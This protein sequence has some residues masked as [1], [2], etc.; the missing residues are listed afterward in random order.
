[1][2]ELFRDTAFGHL[3]RL[4][5]RGKLLQ[6]P[7]ERDPSIWQQYVDEKKSANLAKYG[8]AEPPKDDDEDGNGS[9]EKLEKEQQADDASPTRQRNTTRMPS[10]GSERTRVDEDANATVNR[11]SGVKVDSEKGRD[12]NLVTWYGADDPENPQNWSLGKKCF[13]TAQICLLTT[14]VYIG[15]SIYTAGEESI[16]ETFGVSQVAA[17]LG[18]TLFVAGYGLGP[19]IW[20]PLSEIPQIGRNP[21][22][23]AT[24]VVFVAFQA[25]TALSVNFG[26]LLAFRFL[27]GFF[28][29][30]V[31]ATGGASIGDI[32]SPK[33]RAYAMSIWGIAAVCGPTLGPLV[34][35]FAVEFAPLGGGFTAPWTWPIWELMWLSA[36]CLVFLFFFFPETSANNILVRRARRLRK[37][38]GDDKLISESELMSQE[39]SGKD[40]VMMA[41]VRPFT[42]NF[43]EPMVFL[44]NLYIAL[45]YGLLYIWFESFVVVFVDIY[46]FGL[47]EEGLAYVGILVGAFVV[48]PPFFT[49]LYLVLE[50]QFDE[51]GQVQPEKRLPPCF[52]GAFCIPICLFWFGWSSRPDVFWIVPIIGSAWFSIGAFLLFNSILNYLPDAYPEHA[53]SVL[54]G[55]DFMRS[56]F[57]AGFPLFAS[58]MYGNLGVAWA[59]STLAFISIAFIPIPFVLYK[60]GPTLRNKYSRHARKDI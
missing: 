38:T 35:G 33:K 50:P 59:S 32:W 4:V 26:M 54:A 43:T 23:L 14:S 12:I 37:L 31:L 49:Y 56:S 11:V 29:S 24:L 9:D 34:G 8:T 25:P 30:P 10:S 36:F 40:V 20:S 3:V 42:L 7:E 22:Y 46:H 41:L 5:S 45:I 17:T 6:Y 21:I 19:M 16:I 51:D 52:V 57:G 27:T 2:A 1:M 39:M 18:L 44:L 60:Y 58:A 53:A 28:G 48:I 13:V 55:N 15:S 47:G